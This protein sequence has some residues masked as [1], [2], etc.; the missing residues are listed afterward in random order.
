MKRN[1]DCLGIDF[2]SEMDKMSLIELESHKRTILCDQKK[3]ARQK[4]RALWMIYGDDNTHFFHKF[5]AHRKNLNSIWK[6][7]DDS[8]N[9]V[10]GSEAIAEA[11]IHH[12]EFLFKE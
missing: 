5:A 9:L 10:E 7:N 3:E 11:G 8:G 1:I 4:S 6:I 12:F 2:I